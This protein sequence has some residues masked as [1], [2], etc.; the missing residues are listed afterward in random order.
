[1][2]HYGSL[3]SGALLPSVLQAPTSHR[4][5]VEESAYM[6]MQRV[7]SARLVAT[8]SSLPKELVIFGTAAQQMH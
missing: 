8:L 1:M 6:Q 3:S 4:S 2:V 7:S 5:Y